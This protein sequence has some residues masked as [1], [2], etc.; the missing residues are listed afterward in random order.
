MTCEKNKKN[1][2]NL[3]K[4]KEGES[5]KQLSYGFCNQ[6]EADWLSA[7][8]QSTVYSELLGVLLARTI[9]L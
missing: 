2:K 6:L 5:S 9:L 7:F 3:K 1:K 4:E 8:L